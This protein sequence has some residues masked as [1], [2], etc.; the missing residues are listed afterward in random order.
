MTASALAELAGGWEDGLLLRHRLDDAVLAAADLEDEL[1]DEGLVVVTPDRLVAL[2]EIVALLDLEALQ[3][4]DELGR[5]LTALEAGLLDAQ[6]H[7]VH[8]LEVRLHEAVG[9]RAARIDLLEGD[10]GLV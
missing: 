9:K 5:V 10:D 8:G 1:A 2:R 6:L 4:C 3:G 7:E